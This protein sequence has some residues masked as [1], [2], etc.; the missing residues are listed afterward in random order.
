MLNKK[1]KPG[2]YVSNVILSYKNPSCYSFN[3]FP[4][5]F[6]LPS[7]QSSSLVYVWA[8]V[9]K[10]KPLI[11]LFTAQSPHTPF[12]SKFSVW[13]WVSL[14]TVF[15]RKSLHICGMGSVFASITK[16]DKH[17]APQTGAS[18][19]RHVLSDGPEGLKAKV[20]VQG[21]AARNLPASSHSRLGPPRSG[22]RLR[23]PAAS[24]AVSASTR[25]FFWGPPCSSTTSSSQ[26]RLL[27]PYSPNKAT[28]WGSGGQTVNG[29]F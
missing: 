21:P 4:L 16:G 12:L 8:W 15:V 6:E 14:L 27:W 5:S 10:K 29:R 23:V 22:L 1:F 25:P 24:S 2:N 17:R 9:D 13:S 26:L 7:F 18:N 19:G 3:L 28:V 20:G 11:S